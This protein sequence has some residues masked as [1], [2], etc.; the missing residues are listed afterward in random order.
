M[1]PLAVKVASIFIKFGSRRGISSSGRLPKDISNNTGTASI[2][3][4]LSSSSNSDFADFGFQTVKASQKQDMV[5]EVFSRVANKYDIMND[6]MSMGTH[7]LW[8]DE[9]VSMMGLVR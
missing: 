6:L 5:K 8:K 3:R 7:R 4:S 2:K 1:K 9:F